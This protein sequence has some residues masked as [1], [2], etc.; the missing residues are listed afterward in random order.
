MDQSFIKLHSYQEEDIDEMTE[1][2]NCRITRLKIKGD[3]QITL[4]QRYKTV[5]KGNLNKTHCNHTNIV[6]VSF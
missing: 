2:Y 6:D 1:Q 3:S 5:P 4:K